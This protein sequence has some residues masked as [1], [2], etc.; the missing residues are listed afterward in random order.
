MPGEKSTNKER[1]S[2]PARENELNGTKTFFSAPEVLRRER[3][4][5]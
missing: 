2:A 1:A 3:R 5:S 4:L